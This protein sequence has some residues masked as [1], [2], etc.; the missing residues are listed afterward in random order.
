MRI[1]APTILVGSL[2]NI[3]DIDYYKI[4]VKAGEQLVFADGAQGIGSSLQP[5]VTI[6][7]SDGSVIQSHS[8]SKGFAHTFTTSG[9]YYIKISDYQL[10]GSK[11]HFYRLKIGKFP[12]L[13]SAYPLGVERGKTANIALNGYYLEPKVLLKGEPSGDA[14]DTVNLRPQSHSGISLNKLEL[15][16]GEYKEVESSG[17]NVTIA[18]AQPLAAP[19]T[20][21][22]RI[23][24]SKNEVPPANY[25]RFHANKREDLVIEVNARRLGSP[26]DS[27]VGGRCERRAYRAGNPAR[28]A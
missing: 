8:G 24:G 2:S 5:V 17:S 26:L 19:I 11:N 25:F 15:A 3:G 21:N 9:T 28:G 12:L 16:L 14:R 10:T 7:A 18:S 27:L 4:E 6:L 22:G 13:L 1:R 20:V 23:H